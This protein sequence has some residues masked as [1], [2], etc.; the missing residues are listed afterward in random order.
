MKDHP[1]RRIQYRL[2]SSYKI[3]RQ[4]YQ[5][6]VAV[7]ESRQN[8][9]DHQCLERGWRYQMA[10]LPQLAKYGKTLRHGSLY[11]Y[12]HTQVGVDVNAKVAHRRHRVNHDAVNR[13]RRRR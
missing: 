9:N 11:V 7:V 5:Y 13:Q 2:E 3:G 12:P 4:A 10:N 8:K 6:A 1:C